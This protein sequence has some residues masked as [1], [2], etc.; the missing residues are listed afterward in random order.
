MTLSEE[1]TWEP[2]RGKS[3]ADDIW[4]DDACFDD[5]PMFEIPVVKTISMKIRSRG[6]LEWGPLDGDDL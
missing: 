6:P 3:S 2:M 5:E 4:A 1:P